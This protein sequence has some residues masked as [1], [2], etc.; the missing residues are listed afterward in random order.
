MEQNFRH[1]ISR[2]YNGER[3][4]YDS[5]DTSFYEDGTT[6]EGTDSRTLRTALYSSSTPSKATTNDGFGTRI[7]I[8]NGLH[9]GNVFND[10]NGTADGRKNNKQNSYNDSNRTTNVTNNGMD[11]FNQISKVANYGYNHVPSKNVGA[12]DTTHQR[13]YGDT[14]SECN[15]GNDI[16]A[17]Y[18]YNKTL[19]N[20]TNYY[21]NQNGTIYDVNCANGQ[22]N[23]PRTPAYERANQTPSANDASQVGTAN[24]LYHGSTAWAHSTYVHNNETGKHGHRSSFCNN[25]S[26]EI[27][28]AF[29]QDPEQTTNDHEVYGQTWTVVTM[30]DR[31]IRSLTQADDTVKQEDGINPKLNAAISRKRKLLNET[32]D[33][34]PKAEI[35]NNDVAPTKI[36]KRSLYRK[37]R[38]VKKSKISTTCNESSKFK[39]LLWRVKLG[40]KTI[41]E[42]NDKDGLPN[43]V[44]TAKHSHTVTPRKENEADATIRNIEFITLDNMKVV[45]RKLEV[46]LAVQQEHDHQERLRLDAEV[47]AKVK[48][49]MKPRSRKEKKRKEHKHRG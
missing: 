37:F 40:D 15:A 6:Y 39:P 28:T 48:A 29:R 23:V 47:K 1:K 32:P 46:V 11:N 33:T 38:V 18:D 21:G 5:T 20:N 31:K 4:G 27:A 17:Y 14:E 19:T 24:Q 30:S 34:T 42:V 26:P 10:S 8:T 13:C 43:D 25:T 35:N 12:V 9:Y 41:V 44:K 22:Y 49:N 2:S 3:R 36:D 16:F 7:S 45:R